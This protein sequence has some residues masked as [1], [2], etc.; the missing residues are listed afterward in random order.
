MITKKTKAQA[1]QS[2]GTPVLS[3]LLCY[4]TL[5]LWKEETDKFQKLMFILMSLHTL[6]VD[7]PIISM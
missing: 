1:Y 5:L 4:Y 3:E 6:K 7:L 2:H